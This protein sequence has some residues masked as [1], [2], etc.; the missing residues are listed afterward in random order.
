MQHSTG[1]KQRLGA[2]SKMG[3]RTLR[4]LLIADSDEGAR[5]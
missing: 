1:G 5:L 3:D 4:R 2:T